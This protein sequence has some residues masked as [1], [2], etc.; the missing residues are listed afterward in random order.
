MQQKTT[1]APPARPPG[2]VSV[3]PQEGTFWLFVAPISEIN[4]LVGPVVS[5]GYYFADGWRGSASEWLGLEEPSP[6]PP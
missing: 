2:E 1:E 4:V 3:L 6:A 5:A